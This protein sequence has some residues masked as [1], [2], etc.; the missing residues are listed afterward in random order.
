MSFTLPKMNKT[1]VI[2][3]SFFGFILAGSAVW[4]LLGDVELPYEPRENVITIAGRYCRSEGRDLNEAKDRLE[5]RQERAQEKKDWT[6]SLDL[7]KRIR[8]IEEDISDLRVDCY[9]YRERQEQREPR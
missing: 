2:L 1:M 3:T 6:R 8:D 5:T 7:K 9:R 4:A